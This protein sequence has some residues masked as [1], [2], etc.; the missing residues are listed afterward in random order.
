MRTTMMTMPKAIMMV[1][2][3]PIRID[4]LAS[5]S[6]TLYSIWRDVEP[7]DRAASTASGATR[8]MPR[9]V[10]RTMGGAAKMIVASTAEG[11]PKPNNTKTGIR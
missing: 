5:G 9:L 6:W 7:K 8:R 4:G 11:L 1:W 10:R 3:S 2:F